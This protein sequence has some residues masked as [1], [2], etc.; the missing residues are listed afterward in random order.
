MWKCKHCKKDFDLETTSEKA[1]HSRWC[2]KNPTRNDTE[3]LKKA[4][5]EVLKRKFGD[6]Q[7]FEVLCETCKKFFYVEERSSLFP[8]KEKYFCSRKCACSV[9]GKAKSEKYGNQHYRTICFKFHKKECIICGEKNIVEVHHFDENHG[10]NS[11]ENLIPM[12]PTHHQY[13]H[14]NFKHLIED[15]VNEYHG[16]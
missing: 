5:L 15:K 3:N 14:S 6:Y 13:M 4:Q 8:S 7:T 1:N 12:C 11:K 2:E 10:N 16:A 9:G